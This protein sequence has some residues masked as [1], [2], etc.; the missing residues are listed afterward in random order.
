MK[1][2]AVIA[3]MASACLAQDLSHLPKSCFYE[4]SYYTAKCTAHPVHWY[5]SCKSGFSTDHHGWIPCG[6][7]KAGGMMRCRRYELT[8][9]CE[10]KYFGSRRLQEE[11]AS[12]LPAPAEANLD[13]GLVAP[14]R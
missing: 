3:M 9:E 5:Q 14:P 11:H 7:M 10:D 13:L 2:V 6:F 8:K 12:S 4:Q 1:V